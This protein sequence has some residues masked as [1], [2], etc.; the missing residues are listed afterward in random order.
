[1]VY[2]AINKHSADYKDRYKISMV[3]DNLEQILTDQI[4]GFNM[5]NRILWQIDGLVKDCSNSFAD[6]LE[7]LQSSTEPSKWWHFKC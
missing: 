4:A 2:K 6:A 3:I 7:L 1:M 5:T